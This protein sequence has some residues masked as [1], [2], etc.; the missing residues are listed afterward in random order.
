MISSAPTYVID[1]EGVKT[2]VHKPR[3]SRPPP[4][5]A[6]RRQATLNSPTLQ[7][8][9]RRVR[10]FGKLSEHPGGHQPY[11]LLRR[12]FYWTLMTADYHGV[13]K[14]CASCAKNRVLLRRN[15]KEM[16]LF[17]TAATL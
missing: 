16:E 9:V 3:G 11:Q 7:V 8:S 4:M 15:E 14:K 5:S 13:S 2:S 12:Y 1:W 6:D 10:H 17:P